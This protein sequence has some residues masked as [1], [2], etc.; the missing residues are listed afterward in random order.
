M[1]TAPER[2]QGLVE[3]GS[4]KGA[5]EAEAGIAAASGALPSL[6]AVGRLELPTYGL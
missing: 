1:P 3:C 6:V 5:K 4:R 2:G